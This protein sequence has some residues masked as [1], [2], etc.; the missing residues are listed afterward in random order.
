MAPI[1]GLL[2]QRSDQNFTQRLWTTPSMITNQ[3]ATSTSNGE[4][5]LWPQGLIMPRTT[6]SVRSL[7]NLPR[8]LSEVRCLPAAH[9]RTPVPPDSLLAQHKQHLAYCRSHITSNLLILTCTFWQFSCRSHHM[10]FPA[11]RPVLSSTSLPFTT[12][13]PLSSY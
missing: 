12:Y 7:W 10:Q 4:S 9:G 11:Q 3:R 8:S 13:M 2:K 5:H 6:S 1:A